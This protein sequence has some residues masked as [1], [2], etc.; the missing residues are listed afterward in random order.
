MEKILFKKM[1]SSFAILSLLFIIVFS[2]SFYFIQINSVRNS[3]DEMLTQ[4]ELL[5][6]KSCIDIKE[7]TELYIKDYLNRTYA[8]DF[9]LASN[10]H[11]RNAE[12]LEKI[13]KLMEIE[14]IHIIDDSGKVVLSTDDDFIG[15]DFFEY[16]EIE[17]FWGL[18][19][20]NDR[21][22]NVIQLDACNITDG[23]SKDFVG[24]KS[25]IE[26]YSVIQIG[27]NEKVLE[28][29]RSKSSLESVLEHIPTVYTESLGAVDRSTGD[30]I[31]TTINNPQV[32]VI[33]GITGKTDLI[34]VLKESTKGKVLKVDGTYQ[35]L[36]T[37]FI[38]ND[39]ILYA[40]VSVN[41]YFKEYTY[42][43]FFI[44]GIIVLFIILLIIELSRY[45]RKYILKDF[46]DIADKIKQL[47]HGNYDVHFH[48]EHDTEI[49]ALSSIL[50]DWKDSYK[51][52]SQRMTRL[53]SLLS[54]DVAI[55]ECLYSI[56][57]NFF[58]DNI[59]SI[60][61]VSETKWNEVKDTPS[62]FEKYID[63]L[64]MKVND[65]G[66]ICINDKFISIKL[67]KDNNE[68]YGMILD[69]SKEMNTTHEM[70]CE[71]K[72]VQE[73]ADKDFL[74]N[75]FNRNA[76]EKYVKGQFLNQAD[77]GIM[78]I[79][80]LDNFKSINDLLGHPEGDRV[81][82]I[83]AECLKESFK[84]NQMVARLGGDEFVVFID[85]NLPLGTLQNKLD[86]VLDYLR[87]KLNYYYNEYN[88]STSIGVAYIDNKINSYDELYKCADVALYIAKRMGKDR[89][90]INEDNIRCM[91][92]ECIQCT[93][94]CE[95][96]KALGL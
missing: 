69:K 80:D 32:L 58:S 66:L 82:K 86:S 49:K 62:Q 60:L 85:S 43:L 2:C 12:G 67:F 30:I 93:G 70:K 10:P 41:T 75:L 17:P 87:N 45:L 15:L 95:K 34:K 8:I 5:Y 40:L 16:K 64:M 6:E 47:M 73:T 11:M 92:G 1:A 77:E 52:K 25:T 38:N 71:L 22:A 72:R 29:I 55:F 13:K 14:S 26:G 28:D 19:R 23:V 36:K 94:D 46:L 91:R 51:Y 37:R 7:K 76:F 68:F 21:D 57:N 3:M 27:I 35:F 81:L 31:G 33:D 79:F 78:L 39:I 9:F 90:F 56:N 20:S 18:I 74:T 84:E 61:G 59:V 50:N 54:S 48:T 24:I 89:Y 83:F 4:V 88:I 65:D 44:L 42:Q 53:I 96:R 63:E